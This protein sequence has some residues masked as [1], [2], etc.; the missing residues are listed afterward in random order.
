[1]LESLNDRS[2]FSKRCTLA[3]FIVAAAVMPGAAA[4]FRALI[5][6]KRV[7]LHGLAFDRLPVFHRCFPAFKFGFRFAGIRTSHGVLLSGY[8]NTALADGW[9]I[10][11]VVDVRNA[12]EDNKNEDGFLKMFLSYISSWDL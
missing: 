5:I 10:S 6:L 12:I 3:V 9:F 1:M 7:L 4:F 2:S 11:L 8:K